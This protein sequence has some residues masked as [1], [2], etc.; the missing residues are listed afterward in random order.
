VVSTD[1]LAGSVGWNGAMNDTAGERFAHALAAKDKDGLRAVLADE[2]DFRGLTPGRYWE[3]TTSQQAVDD[4]ILG[5]WFEP[6]DHI[7]ELC[8]VTDDTVADRSHVAYRLRVRN[9]DGEFLVEQ[10]AYYTAV[11][12][13]ITWMRV[14]CSGYRPAAGA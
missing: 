3:A 9:S 12:G 10:Q 2:I 13:A 8:S 7:E 1:V 6:D 11:D 4:I 5:H 14:L